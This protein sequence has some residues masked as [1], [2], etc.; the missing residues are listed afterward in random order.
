MSQPHLRQQ[1]GGRPSQGPPPDVA[2]PEPPPSYGSDF[3]DKPESTTAAEPQDQPDLDEFAAKLGLTDDDGS[4][5]A[6][7]AGESEPDGRSAVSLVRRRGLGLARRAAGAL[8][9]GLGTLSRR[10]ERFAD[11]LGDGANADG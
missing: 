7:P 9:G 10:L 11:D 2:N 5:P 6:A 4:A 3:P 8:A 1:A